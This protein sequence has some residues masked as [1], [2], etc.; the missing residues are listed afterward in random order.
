MFWTSVFNGR[1]ETRG[2]GMLHSLSNTQLSQH[3]QVDDFFSR[4]GIFEKI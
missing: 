2:V 1:D 4:G 3:L